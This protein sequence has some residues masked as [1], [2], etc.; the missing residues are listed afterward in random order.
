MNKNGAGID[1]GA[2]REENTQDNSA[3]ECEQIGNAEKTSSN[4]PRR[5]MYL[6]LRYFL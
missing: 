3:N 6:S 4:I 1:R 5:K 2:K